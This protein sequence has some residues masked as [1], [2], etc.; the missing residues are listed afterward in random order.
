MNI[1]FFGAGASYGSS[2]ASTPPLGP[3]LFAALQRHDPNSWG[4]L[5]AP[6]PARFLVDFEEAMAEFI[7]VGLFAAPLQWAMADFFF[8]KFLIDDTNLYIRLLQDIARSEQDVALVTINYDRLLFQAAAGIVTLEVGDTIRPG[9]NLGLC[10]PHGSS[11]LKCESVRGSTGVSFTGGVSTR[12]K[13]SLINDV[14]EF[15]RERGSNVF[16][17][18]MSYFE[19][20]KFTCS[21][22]NF[23][24]G[25]RQLFSELIGGAS[26]V[27]II[28]VNVHPLDAHIWDPLEQTPAKCF[29]LGGAAGAEK[30]RSWC[31][32]TNRG[33]DVVCERYFADGYDEMVAFILGI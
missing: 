33:D 15:D 3:D 30:Y 14:S 5:A 2:N 11:V 32:D 23:I 29:Y 9:K 19:P 10:L 28:G 16:P 21:G 27:A 22:A 18:V 17:P 20:N 13:I 31:Q 25:Q 4:R 8:K 7:A 1:L 24:A 12:G 26:R 6:W